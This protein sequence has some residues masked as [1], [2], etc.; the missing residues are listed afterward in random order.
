[1]DDCTQNLLSQFLDK[2]KK[3][4]TSKEEILKILEEVLSKEERRY[5]QDIYISR[6]NNLIIKVNSSVWGYQFNLLIPEIL[7]L[8]KEKNIEVNEIKIKVRR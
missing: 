4:K 7:R 6:K 8:L 2:L 5:I 3:K 1:V